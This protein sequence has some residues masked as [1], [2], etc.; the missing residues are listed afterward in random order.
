MVMN[1]MIIFTPMTCCC[2]NAIGVTGLISGITSINYLRAAY[3]LRD[4]I[5]QITTVGVDKCDPYNE[6][7]YRVL[8]IMA[9]I[10]WYDEM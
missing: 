4:S 7:I 6:K 2:T 9:F 1:I 5:I 3:Q 8:Y 10:S